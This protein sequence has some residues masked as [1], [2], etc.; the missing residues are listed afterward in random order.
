VKRILLLLFFVILAAP[1]FL[2]PLSNSAHAASYEAKNSLVC[3]Q[4]ICTGQDPYADGCVAD[5]VTQYTFSAYIY[6]GSKRVGL[7]EMRR[8]NTCG[9]LWTRVTSYIGSASLYGQIYDANTPNYQE[10]FSYYGTSLYT[11]MLNFQFDDTMVAVGCVGSYCNR[12]QGVAWG[13]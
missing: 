3:P 9:S 5:A 2:V 8:S 10:N 6:Q 13:T 7:V 1:I 11:N 12:V 4:N